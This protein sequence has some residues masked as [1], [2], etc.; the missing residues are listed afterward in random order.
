MMAEKRMFTQKIIDSDAFLEMPLSAQAL[1]FH[2]NMR[3][4]DDGFVNNPKRITKLV[5]ASDD[6]LKI[7][8]LKRFI[9]GFDSGVIVIKHWRMHNTLKSDRYHPT[10]YQ[11]EF[12]QL[13]IKPNK[14]YTD[15]LD[16]L[17]P[18]GTKM[19][20]E[21]NQNGSNLEPEIREVL[22]E[23]S[24]DKG[25]TSSSSC[26]EK[27]SGITLILNDGSEY[28]IVEDYISKM[29][30]LFP[31]VNVRKELRKMS[32]WCINNPSRRKTKRGITRFINSWLSSA[33]KEAEKEEAKNG[34]DTNNIFLQIAEERHDGR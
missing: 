5:N 13:G 27:R 9:I 2:L 10:D 3:A 11:E 33:Q 14:A 6:D 17:L 19:E 12:A 22:E 20:P 25:S 26:A 1:Y 32:A 29:L 28:E 7:L 4:D 15:H 31:N 16:K 8:L 30:T 21:W 23:I 18:P 34:S 24:K